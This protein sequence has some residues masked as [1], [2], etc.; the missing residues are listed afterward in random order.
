MQTSLAL[1]GI[2]NVQ[3]RTAVRAGK[4]DAGPI[5]PPLTATEVALKYYAS[6]NDKNM[7]AVLDLI[8]DNC[9]YQDLVYQEPFVGRAAVAKYF[10]EIERMVPADIKFVVE[11]IT[12][13]DDRKVGVR[14]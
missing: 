7:A 6:Y 11:D 5:A 12:N 10:E 13:G 2:R 1:L 9:V 3:Y 8:A 4:G 14:W